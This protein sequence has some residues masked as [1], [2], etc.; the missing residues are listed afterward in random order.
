MIIIIIKKTLFFFP[1]NYGIL[2]TRVIIIIIRVHK[3]YTRRIV[4]NMYTR[5]S[6]ARGG[7]V[8]KYRLQ[9]FRSRSS[10]FQ[11]KFSWC[12]RTC[13]YAYLQVTTVRIYGLM[14]TRGCNLIITRHSLSPPYDMIVIL[15]ER[16]C[17][18]YYY[19]ISRM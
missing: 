17:V 13:S 16:V 19:T 12:P 11:R 5:S 6:Y 3:T 8:V 10:F 2:Y 9:V 1:Q 7:G 15:R 14:V 4:Y 18:C